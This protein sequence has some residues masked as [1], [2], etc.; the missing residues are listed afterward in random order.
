M[1]EVKQIGEGCEHRFK[2]RGW[3]GGLLKTI[4]TSCERTIE[5]GDTDWE[6]KAVKPQSPKV[7]TKEVKGT[8]RTVTLKAFEQFLAAEETEHQNKLA[9]KSEITFNQEYES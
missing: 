4:C 2:I 5:I 6:G 3:H 8:Y 1:T 7:E 9:A